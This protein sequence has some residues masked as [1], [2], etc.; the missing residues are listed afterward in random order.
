MAVCKERFERKSA[1]LSVVFCKG[2]LLSLLFCR[3]VSHVTENLKDIKGQTQVGWNTSKM[4]LFKHYSDAYKT[5]P[6]PFNWWALL[7]AALFLCLLPPTAHVSFRN[8]KPE[9]GCHKYAIKRPTIAERGT[10][11]GTLAITLHVGRASGVVA[12]S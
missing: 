4:H 7:L 3:F 5:L 9:E 1:M 2:V 12:V 11:D 8:T 6:H 10:A